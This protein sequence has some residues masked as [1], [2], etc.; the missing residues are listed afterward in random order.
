M[1]YYMYHY[2]HGRRVRLKGY[3]CINV[4]EIVISWWTL[5]KTQLK[6]TT[7]CWFVC[8]DVVI[9]KCVLVILVKAQSCHFSDTPENQVIF[10]IAYTFSGIKFFSGVLASFLISFWHSWG[11]NQYLLQRSKKFWNL[12]QSPLVASLKVALLFYGY[13]L[14]AKYFCHSGIIQRKAPIMR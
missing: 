13:K 7:H 8:I 6:S 4:S 14:Y 9:N 1:K 3:W 5:L 11:L 12:Y 2:V 10:R